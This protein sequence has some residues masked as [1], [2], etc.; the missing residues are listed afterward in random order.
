MASWKPLEDFK[1]ESPGVNK[2]PQEIWVKADLL[3][4]TASQISV[5]EWGDSLDSSRLQYMRAITS[6]CKM[7]FDHFAALG[8]FDTS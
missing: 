5:H 4:R 2:V 1:W 6:N 8:K 3:D 7:L